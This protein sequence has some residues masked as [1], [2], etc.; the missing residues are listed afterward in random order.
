[1]M[2]NNDKV[3]LIVSQSFLLA[4][5]LTMCQNSNRVLKLAV[6]AYILQQIASSLPPIHTG[7]D[8]LNYGMLP[9]R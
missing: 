8:V 5:M 6:P 7:K 2:Q 1:M 9:Y 4:K 3:P